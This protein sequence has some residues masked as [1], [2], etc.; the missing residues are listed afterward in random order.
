MAAQTQAAVE[1]GGRIPLRLEEKTGE[2]LAR[3]HQAIAKRA[4]ERFEERQAVHGG[5]LEDWL[6][7]ER[8]ILVPATAALNESADTL[9]V[10]LSLGEEFSSAGLTVGIDSARIILSGPAQNGDDGAEPSAA[11]EGPV[12]FRV[13]ELPVNIDTA[14][15][16]A[17][18]EEGNLRITLAKAPAPGD[19]DAR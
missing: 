13:I 18:L 1:H 4:Y 10:F 11:V 9:D 5:D 2:L 6:A 14:C 15:S 19:F 17:F 12:V 16:A 7:A 8:E 3:M